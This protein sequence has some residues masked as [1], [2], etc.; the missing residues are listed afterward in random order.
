[1]KRSA[2][3]FELDEPLTPS[4]KRASDSNN[5]PLT[6]PKSPLDDAIERIQE[7]I[8]KARQLNNQT[9]MDQFTIPTKNSFDVLATKQAENV[10]SKPQRSQKTIKLPPITIVGASNFNEA[11][12]I[13]NESYSNTEYTIK[14]M[15]IGT[16]ILLN[17]SEV[18]IKFKNSLNTAGIEYF[19]HDV[20][21]EKYDKFVL[22][23]ITKTTIQNIID[24][25]KIYQL[26][27]VEVKEI[28]L[29]NKKFNDESSYIV[30]FKLRSVKMANLNKVR[31]DYTIPNWRPFQKSSNNITQC[32]RCQMYG[33]GMRN[34]NVN[35]KCA[36]CGLSHSK[37]NCNSPIKK[38]INCKGDHE[39]TFSECPKRK[40]FI[41]MRTRI[42]SSHNRSTKSSRVPVSNLE[43]F[44]ALVKKSTA[45]QNVQEQHMA[46]TTDWSNIVKRN[47]NETETET[48][49][50]TGSQKFKIEEIGPIMQDLLSSLSSCQNKQEQLTVMFVM[51]T[52]WIY[53]NTP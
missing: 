44:P 51:A 12:K 3:E 21:P 4:S 27:P 11:I 7:T 10:E 41:L 5:Q 15:T 25:L 26:E 32:R 43:N 22:S 45:F 39:S 46:S 24:A 8:M 31:I 53:N 47:S 19:S 23:G 13:L 40:E 49:S 38:C 18:H 29:K 30:S 34:C 2:S 50:R 28:L 36:I 14:Y 37:E 35:V 16:K 1:M 52:K 48:D 42:A 17:N 6:T 9:L 20:N 33:H